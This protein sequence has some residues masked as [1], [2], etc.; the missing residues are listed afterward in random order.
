MPIT[1]DSEL[2]GELERNAHLWLVEPRQ[3]VEAGLLP[4]WLDLLDESERARIERFRFEHDR[5]LYAAAH[6]L[7]RTT[8]ARYVAVEPARLRFETGATGK[9]CLDPV[10]NP[11]RLRFSLSHSQG[12]AACFVARHAEPGVDVEGLVN[13]SRMLEIAERYFA[14][15]EANALG[16]L[17]GRA[18]RDRFYCLW[19]LKEALIKAK[20]V[21]LSFT[22]DK[23]AFE[24]AGE[25]IR[26]ASQ[27]ADDTAELQFALWCTKTDHVVAAAVR[28]DGTDVEPLH[29]Q[30]RRTVPLGQD[31]ADAG[32]TCVAASRAC[33]SR[34]LIR[35]E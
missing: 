35:G 12:L 2:A 9:P 30:V 25:S 14:V 29:L 20:G 18:L 31:L 6:A 8:L 19:T 32:V 5:N 15:P 23:F 22:L 21:G 13:R 28:H 3:G 11:L 7:V 26:V 24:I 4:A 1:D 17:S 27:G 16:Q 33:G 34:Q 10:Q